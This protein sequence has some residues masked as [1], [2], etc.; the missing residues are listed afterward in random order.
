[1]PRN[2]PGALRAT[3]PRVPLWTHEGGRID[4]LSLPTSAAIRLAEHTGGVDHHV[5]PGNTARFLATYRRFLH[6]SGG[7]LRLVAS[8]CPAC[9]GCQYDDI[10]VVR[11]A[12]QSTLLSLPLR[13]RTEFQ[14]LLTA[15][16]LEFRRRTLPSLVPVRGGLAWW[17]RRLYEGD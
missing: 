17:H 6:T 8:S 15:L 4:R 5:S 1:M 10:A 9:P 2:R 3:A 7:R 11:D 13:P 14:L 12:S 16:D